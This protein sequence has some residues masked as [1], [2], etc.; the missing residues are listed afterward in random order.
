MGTGSSDLRLYELVS[1]GFYFFSLCSLSPHRIPR[2]ATFGSE[3]STYPPHRGVLVLESIRHF[4]G[5]TAKVLPAAVGIKPAEV[6]LPARQT[7]KVDILGYP[8]I[9][10][11]FFF[12][13]RSSL[14]RSKTAN[15]WRFLGRRSKSAKVRR[16]PYTSVTLYLDDRL[17]LVRVRVRVRTLVPWF[18][19]LQDCSVV[20]E[21]VA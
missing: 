8:G 18:S 9:K 15:S 17:T 13:K 3:S 20:A 11:R 2:D 10:Y 21:F 4:G 12:A 14:W 5:K 16:V 7:A 19:L 1:Q 6:G